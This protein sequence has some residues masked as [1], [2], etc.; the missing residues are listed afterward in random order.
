MKTTKQREELYKA[1]NRKRDSDI[2][3]HRKTVTAALNA[4]IQPLL[5][6]IRATGTYNQNQ[7]QLIKE[8]ELRE[9]VRIIFETTGFRF[10]RTTETT[11]TKTK[12][13]AL[14][15]VSFSQL[16]D[17]LLND[18]SPGGLGM[19]IRS[20]NETTRKLVA[21]DIALFLDEGAAINELATLLEK[22]YKDINRVRG[23]AISRTETIKASNYGALEGA[24]ASGVPFVKEWNSILDSRTRASHSSADGKRVAHDE[25]FT[26]GG[27]RLMYPVDT[28]LGASGKNT[29][30]CRCVIDFVDPEEGLA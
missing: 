5:N 27:E 8:D 1:V 7:L 15:S 30:N 19:L 25:A 21:A 12:K 29:V 10:A 14:E 16:V 3:H 18:F 26:V 9:A 22:K 24:K 13:K 4:S 2:R 17:G 23:L 11:L 6:R 20:M 28:S